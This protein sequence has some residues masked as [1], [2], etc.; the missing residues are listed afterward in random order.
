MGLISEEERNFVLQTL[1][2]SHFSRPHTH[3]HT[4]K[5]KCTF[6]ST[7]AEAH[8]HSRHC[9]ASGTGA[10]PQ[11]FPTKP[12][13]HHNE[14]YPA[15]LITCTTH[16][17]THKDLGHAC[18]GAPTRCAAWLGE[19]DIIGQGKQCV[20]SGQLYRDVEICPVSNCS[21]IN[22]RNWIWILSWQ[23]D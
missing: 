3:T 16:T 2:G 5:L 20:S 14:H 12:V 1:A 8:V 21:R 7:N 19:S 15:A 18:L 11:L 22:G 23:S 10:E 6:T 4:H 9:G 17:H 13:H